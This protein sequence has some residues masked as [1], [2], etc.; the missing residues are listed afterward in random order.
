MNY[1]K[2]YYYIHIAFIIHVGFRQID[3]FKVLEQLKLVS[4]LSVSTSLEKSF[5]ETVKGLT[6]SSNNQNEWQFSSTCYYF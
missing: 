6:I 2:V 4:V 3:P 5:N 1:T